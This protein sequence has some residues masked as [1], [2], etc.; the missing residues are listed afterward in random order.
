MKGIVDEVAALRLELTHYAT[1][2]PHP[3][4]AE[5]EQSRLSTA[6]APPLG[7]LTQRKL[8]AVAGFR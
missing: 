4:R 5:H 3:P 7:E 6:S 1:N 8:S 2:T